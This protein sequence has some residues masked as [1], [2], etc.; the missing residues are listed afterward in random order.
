MFHISYSEDEYN[1]YSLKFG[2]NF[3][4]NI[5]AEAIHEIFKNLDLSE[6][7]S[8]LNEDSIN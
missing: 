3:E 7:E 2:S 8:Q 4:A 1:I 5:G 6:V